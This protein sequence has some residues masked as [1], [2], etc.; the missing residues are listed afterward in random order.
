L[1]ITRR[2]FC[3]GAAV[4][5]VGTAFVSWAS[6]FAGFFGVADAQTTSLADLLQPGPLPDMAMGDEKA[7]CT[8]IEYASLTCPHCRHFAMTTFPE[9][10]KRYIDTG[11]VRYIFR[12]FVLNELDALAILLARC[13]DKDKYFPF[14]ETLYETQEQWVVRNAI[15]PLMGIAKQVGF[16][17]DSFNKCAANQSLLDSVKLQRD[18]AAKFGVDSTP[19][20]FINGRIQSGDMPIDR[21]EKLIE[22]Y[23]KA[24]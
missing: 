3:A 22:P 19:T 4:I 15:P 16:T 2:E 10:K 23:L 20:F 13:A 24:G 18:R 8:I 9:L 5:G 11:K 12:E 1:I 21:L 7:A 17:E 14:V 6:P